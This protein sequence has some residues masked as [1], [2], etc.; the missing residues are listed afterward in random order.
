MQPDHYPPQEPLSPQAKAY[1]DEVMRRGQSVVGEQHHYGDDPYQSILLCRAG[2]PH[3]AILAFLHGGGWTN[4]YKEW[5]AFMAPAFTAAGITFASIG[6]RLAP[7]HP[8]PTGFNDACAGV[9]WLADNA[10]SFGGDRHRLFVGG[11]SAGGHYAALMALTRPDLHLRGCLPLSGVYDFGPESGLTMR[12]RFL[13]EVELENELLA[14]PIAHIGASPCAFLIAYGS[15]DFPHLM[16][17]GERMEQKLRAAG[18]DVERLVLQGRNHFTASY[19]G[20][21]P[22][23]PWVTAA[24]AWIARHAG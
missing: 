13:G 2:A 1:N 14:S 19:A 16:K 6:Y 23:G 5:M 11:H 8:F 21:E 12:P 18:G 20:G 3:S 7:E 15:D 9:A 22:D 4:G 17:Q 24:T 10:A